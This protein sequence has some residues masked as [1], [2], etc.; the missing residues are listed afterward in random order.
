MVNTLNN[1]LQNLRFAAV[2][3]LFFF[4]LCFA[5]VVL[6]PPSAQAC[7]WA[8]AQDD[9]DNAGDFIDDAHTDIRN[10]VAVE[11]DADLAAFEDWMIEVMFDEHFVPALGAMATQMGSVAMYYTSMIGMFFDAQIQMDTQRLFRKLQFEAHKDY[12]PSESFCYFGTNVRSLAASESIGQFNSL[13]LS[14]ISLDRQLGAFGVVGAKKGYKGDYKARWGQFVKTYCD[15]GDNNYSGAG[16][17]LTYACDHDGPNGNSDMGAENNNRIN[18]DI[19]YTRLVDEPRTIDL[20]FSNDTL[21][22]ENPF[23]ITEPGDEEDIIALS[24]NLYGHKVLS[25]NIAGTL[26][27]S[28]NAQKLFLALRSIAAKRGVAQ[29]SFNAI[30]GMKSSGTT[31][32]D[33]LDLIIYRATSTPSTRLLKQTR[34]YMAAI[35]HQLLPS[36]PDG[37]GAN[38]FDL[39]GY[40]P[41]YYSQ[42][43]VL[44]KRIYQNPDFYANLYD[45]PANVSRKKVAMRAI[46]LMVDRAIYE[47]QLRREMNVSVLLSSKL[48]AAHRLADKGLATSKGS[49]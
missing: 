38:I 32:M 12:R 40:S 25:R 36:D 6:T 45:T 11:F 43:E 48:R 49:E 5:G 27:K 28:N 31:H 10:R 33:E 20:D 39:I 8:C 3:A 46:E 24:K 35:M 9:C 47:S 34:R 42:L 29:A 22:T 16:T 26:M 21:N 14:R 30:I 1:K 18:R 44:A 13:S 2:Y 37:F 4:A 19:D 17:G 41:S 23:K 7:C 15:I